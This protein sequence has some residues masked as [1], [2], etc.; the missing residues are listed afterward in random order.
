MQNIVMISICWHFP[1]HKDLFHKNFKKKTLLSIVLKKL[2]SRIRIKNKIWI[3]L[4]GGYNI[5]NVAKCWTYITAQ[6]LGREIS[7][8]IPEHE[9]CSKMVM[10]I[11]YWCFRDCTCLAGSWVLVVFVVTAL[12]SL[13][14]GITNVIGREILAP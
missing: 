13:I 10:L 6:L 1:L 3:C 11:L 7:D 5:P 2:S 4:S 12:L 9:V 14:L 8:D